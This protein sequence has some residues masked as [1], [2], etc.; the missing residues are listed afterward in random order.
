MSITKKRDIST[1]MYKESMSS[2]YLDLLGWLLAYRYRTN[3]KFDSWQTVEMHMLSL[4][5][6]SLINTKD[7]YMR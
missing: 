4:L 3:I 6:G 5:P 1:V 2:Y 7:K